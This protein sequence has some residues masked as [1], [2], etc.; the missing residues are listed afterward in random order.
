LEVEKSLGGVIGNL[1]P[2]TT[3]NWMFLTELSNG[4]EGMQETSMLTC[5]VKLPFNCLEVTL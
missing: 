1:G 4:V 5:T 3:S 2:A